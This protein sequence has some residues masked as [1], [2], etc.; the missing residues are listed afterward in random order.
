MR[1]LKFNPQA[2]FPQICELT[3]G[4][5]VSSSELEVTLSSRRQ[6]QSAIVLG[7]YEYLKS[8][9]LAHEITVANSQYRLGW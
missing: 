2:P 5:F 1:V 8:F 7:K 3:S 6:F 4:T 9:F